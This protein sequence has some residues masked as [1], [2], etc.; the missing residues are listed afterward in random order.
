MSFLFAALIIATMLFNAYIRQE[1]FRVPGVLPSDECMRYDTQNG[2]NFDL[3]FVKGEYLQKE[4]RE[5]K[6]AFPEDLPEERVVALGLVSLS[7]VEELREK[8]A[9]PEDLLPERAGMALDPVSLVSLAVDEE[10]AKIAPPAFGYFWTTYGEA[11]T[12]EVQSDYGSIHG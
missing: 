6:E 2:D 12:D 11:T 9:F 5:E 3:S 7:A 10:E 8:E 4:L 1:H